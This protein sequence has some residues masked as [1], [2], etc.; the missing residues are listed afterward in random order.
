M[1]LLWH[2]ALRRRLERIAFAL[3][4]LFAGILLQTGMG[5]LMGAVALQ[6]LHLFALFIAIAFLLVAIHKFVEDTRPTPPQ[7]VK[8]RGGRPRAV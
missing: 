2:V 1:A 3:L 7:D 5:V 4:E 6:S 8:Q